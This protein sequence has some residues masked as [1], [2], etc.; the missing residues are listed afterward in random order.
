MLDA[1][2][3]E[4]EEYAKQ[5]APNEAV[6]LLVNCRGHERLHK[7]RNIAERPK[8]YF[9][10]HE[11][12]YADAEDR[13]DVIAVLHSHPSGTADPSHADRVECERSG[14]VW[15]ILGLLG[16]AWQRIEPCG[17]KL[18]LKGRQFEHGIVDCYALV[19]DYFKECN[20]VELPDYERQDDW[21][22]KGQDLYA[23][24]FE[25]EGFIKVYDEPRVHD[26]FLIQIQADVANHAAIYLG[27]G[28]ILHHYWGRLSCT[29]IYGGYWQ[30]HTRY[31][32]RYAR[33]QAIRPPG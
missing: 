9:H 15:Y 6:A 7:C 31:H 25:K 26:V 17:F 19:R 2:R 33:N 11:E 8:D 29:E 4:F 1:N 14:K 13:G 28:V 12:D 5:Q 23:Q 32:V 10:L 27:D 18:P 3:L 16:M 20:I 21:W 30:K 22:K 24:H